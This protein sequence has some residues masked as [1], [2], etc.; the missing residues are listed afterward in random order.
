MIDMF[1]FYIYIYI[2]IDRVL[3]LCFDIDIHIDGWVADLPF[4]IPLDTFL[5]CCA[6]SGA[7][8]WDT[9]GPRGRGPVCCSA[10]TQ[11]TLLLALSGGSVR[12]CL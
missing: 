4:D 6:F 9:F 10:L 12:L 1:S 3:S 5:F 8:D 7:I 11:V 2:Y